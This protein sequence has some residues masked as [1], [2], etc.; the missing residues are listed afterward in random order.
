MEKLPEPAFHGQG[1]SCEWKDYYSKEQ[2]QAAQRRIE[3]LERA[4]DV[5]RW[6]GPMH[7]AWGKAIPD[8]QAAFK[9]LLE[10]ALQEAE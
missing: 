8:T 7:D 10:A 9:A 2:M 6:S 3:R 5:R 4:F 1:E